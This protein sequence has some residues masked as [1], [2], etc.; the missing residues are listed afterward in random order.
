MTIQGTLRT[1]DPEVRAHSLFYIEKQASLIAKSFGGSA[2][3]AVQKGYDALINH[4]E[5]MTVIVQNAAQLLGKQNLYQKDFPSL[6][7]EDFSFFLAKTPGAFFH[8][9]CGNKKEKKTAPLHS[10]DFE[11]DES[12]IPIGVELQVM[13]VFSLLAKETDFAP[14]T[15]LI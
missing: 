1:T 11:L 8:L 15:D 5:V 2:D 3:V 4:D 6:G 13:N 14:K 9:G 7:V 12:C 10:S